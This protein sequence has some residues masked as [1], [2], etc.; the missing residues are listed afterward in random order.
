MN[1]KCLGPIA[2]LEKHLPS[3]WWRSIFNSIYLKTDAD[4]VENNEATAK[5]IDIFLGISHVEPSDTILDLC[6]GQGRHSL[7]LA[8]RGYQ[9]ISG[10]DRSRYLIRLAKGRAQKLGH[11]IKFSEGDARKIRIRDQTIDCVM[12][13]G[14]SF[15]YFEKEH[16]DLQVLKEANRVLHEEGLLY[17]D[18]TDGLW[19]KENFEKRSWEWIDEEFMVCR[20]R[21][22]AADQSR[23]ISREL[24]IHSEKGVLAD[25]F[26]A[27]RLYTFQEL[28]SQ[29]IAA[30]FENIKKQ[31]NLLGNSTRN[32]DLGMM[33]NRILITASAPKKKQP[34]AISVRSKIHCTVLMGDP[35]LPDAVKRD[36]QFNPEDFDTIHRLKEALDQLNGFKFSYFDHHKSLVKKFSQNPPQFVMNLCDEGWQNDPFMELHPTALMEMLNIPYSG[37]GPECLSVCYNKATVCAI[38]QGMDIPT[39]SEIWIDPF[40][41]SGAI[42]GIFPAIIKPAYGD[43]S[44]GI[45]QNAVVYSPED[46][47]TY[48][49]EL[50]GKMPEVPVLIQEFLEGR[51]F[52]VGL[53]GN[54]TSLEALP[55]LEVDY[56]K[57]PP[58]LPK[59]LGYESKWLFDSPYCTQIQYHRAQLDECIERSLI[60]ASISLFQRLKCRD[61][62]RFDFRMNAQGQPKLLEV[63]PN[64]GWCWD[65]KM[66]I[67][68]QF[69]GIAYH[70]LLENVL[71][72]ALERY[73]QEML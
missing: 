61:Y 37:A 64:P 67:M 66:A 12:I 73:P 26:Y 34:K 15:G 2:D 68:A 42:P 35:R 21:H 13:M 36:G 53:I 11:S 24:V 31:E 22:L 16:E 20:E 70:N 47:V 55:V 8:K 51:E 38:A 7:E 69:A 6:C 60:D 3:D 59:I 52:S 33:A 62:A 49:D 17:L 57:L 10:I 45:T 5:E 58:Q 39:P 54:G 32:Q 1:V 18:V 44:I 46:F 27:E 50:K 19:M 72:A 28:E 56:S 30:G 14:N 41:H 23:L 43:S 40:S 63:N 71:K 65:G 48:F 4:V 9:F 25:Q 29:L